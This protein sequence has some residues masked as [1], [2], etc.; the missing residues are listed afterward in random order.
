MTA[1]ILVG[2]DGSPAAQTALDWAL[3]R[4][5][6]TGCDVEV[7]F[8]ADTSWDS[9]AFTAAPLLHAK[10]EVVLAGAAFHADSKAPH[11]T[12]SSKVL[13][14]NPVSVLVAEAEAIGASLLVVGSYRKD[15]YE[16]LT[17]SAVSL[18]VAASATVPVAV[19]PD[20]PAGR[21]HGVVV[22]V[23]GGPSSVRLA[24]TALVEAERLG[25]PLRIL[26]AW[27]LPPLVQ[28]DFTDGSDLYDA[29][30]ER[31]QDV[32]RQ[33]AADVAGTGATGPDA[34]GVDA[35]AASVAVATDVVLAAPAAAL[36]TAAADAALL[37][38]GSHGRHGI[39]RFLLGSVSHDVL[40]SAPCPVLV[41]RVT[42]KG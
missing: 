11:V 8:V 30:E 32:A 31:A 42:D 9:E 3:R 12:V 16:R 18:R 22:G 14:G 33:V 21:R 2:F 38:V 17:T 13:S 26:T 1:S 34:T 6:A 28:P 5:E 35:P 29:L 19:I 7:L 39:G 41:L 15:L 4:A 36:V 20:L 24:R 25:E 10:G 37:V 40:L 23:D 27:T